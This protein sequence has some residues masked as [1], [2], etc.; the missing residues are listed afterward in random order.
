MVSWLDY[1]FWMYIAKVNEISWQVV[2]L[3]VEIVLELSL[4]SSIQLYF[5]AGVA[6]L[7][8][9]FSD[10]LSILCPEVA[11]IAQ[12]IIGKAMR[13]VERTGRLFEA[14]IE[15]YQQWTTCLYLLYFI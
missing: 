14:S 13:K 12:S 2:L 6:W 4:S 15:S 3:A 11:L 9:T 10:S 7:F 5:V 8:K 1:G